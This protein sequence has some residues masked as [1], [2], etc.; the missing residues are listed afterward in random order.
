[1]GRLGKGSHF[2]DVIDA[3]YYKPLR[4]G[5]TGGGTHRLFPS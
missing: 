2:G 1:M 4:A 5:I 3:G